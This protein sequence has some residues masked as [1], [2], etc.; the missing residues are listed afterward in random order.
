MSSIAQTIFKSLNACVLGALVLLAPL[1]AVMAAERE[2]VVRVVRLNLRSR[3]S[4]DSVPLHELRQG[5]RLIVLETATRWL[6]VDYDDL[7]GY[8]R[9]HPRY[10]DTTLALDRTQSEKQALHQALKEHRRYLKEMAGQE[11]KLIERLERLARAINRNRQQ[12]AALRTELTALD[13]KIA[14]AAEESR[15]LDARIVRNTA[16]VSRRLVAL[17]KLNRLGTANLLASAGSVNEMVQ[18]RNALEFILSDDEKQRRQLTADLDRWSSL[19]RELEANRSD[20]RKLEKMRRQNLDRLYHEKVQRNLLLQDTRNIQALKQ[21]ALVSLQASARELDKTIKALSRS[22][23][24]DSARAKAA[25]GSFGRLKGLLKKPVR[26]K[27]INFFGPFQNTRY[28]VTNYRSGVDFRSDRGEP[29][30]S[31]SAGRVI[32]A[33]WFKSYGNMMIIDHGH[34]YCTLYAHLEEMFK[35]K[36]DKVTSDEVIATVGESGALSG[37]G[38]YFEVR[39]HGKPEDPQLWLI[40]D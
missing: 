30:K 15:L 10:I 7:V 18:R 32:Y 19:R 34:S 9:N 36:G 17:Y 28:N 16:D 22:S 5:D 6:K 23:V 25:P 4:V 38:L 35:Q 40:D 37:S 21:A 12:L 24:V 39:H 3:P 26:G 27:I 2:A 8:V 13:R 33:D 20:K 31:V 11:K 1:A 14:R 29:I